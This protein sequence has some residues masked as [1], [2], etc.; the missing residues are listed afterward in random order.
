[1]SP[2]FPQVLYGPQITP[3]QQA[4]LAAR[5]NDAVGLEN[6]IKNGAEAFQRN[7]NGV[8][9]VQEVC[10]NHSLDCLDVLWELDPS[11]DRWQSISRWAAEQHLDATV[12]HLMGKGVVSPIH[13]E[14]ED[15]TL[16]MVNQALATLDDRRQRLGISR[17]EEH[18]AEL[19]PLLPF[20]DRVRIVPAP[21]GQSP[22][23]AERKA[24]ETGAALIF[25]EADQGP[26]LFLSESLAQRL[27]P[28]LAPP[29]PEEAVSPPRRRGPGMH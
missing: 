24:W 14:P 6:A 20:L 8:A 5:V 11:I 19:L 4:L 16:E 18:G 1:M 17:E 13:W 23:P 26:T 15:I 2:K 7:K 21:A 9:V 29:A 3:Q 25:Q 27:A 10:Q 28:V 22:T 12:V